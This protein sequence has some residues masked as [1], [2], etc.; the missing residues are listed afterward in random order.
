[1]LFLHSLGVFPLVWFVF[2]IVFHI[3]NSLRYFFNEQLKKNPDTSFNYCSQKLSASDWSNGQACD[4]IPFQ[5]AAFEMLMQAKW[6][7]ERDE[8][9]EKLW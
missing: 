6:T 2:Q 5:Q 3:I 8:T 7:Q 1:M 9:N 4:H